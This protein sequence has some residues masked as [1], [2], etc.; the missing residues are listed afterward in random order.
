M[1]VVWDQIIIHSCMA[2]EEYAKRAPHI[3][4]EP[5]PA[6]APKL[7]PVDRAW[8]YIKYDRIPNFTPSTVHQ[9]RKEVGKELQRLQGHSHLLRSFIKYSALPPFLATGN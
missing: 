9:L 8:F 3:K 7:N 6:Y 4:L 2:V 1:T 5:F